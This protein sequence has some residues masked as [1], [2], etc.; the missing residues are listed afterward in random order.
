MKYS[1]AFFF[2]FFSFFF[3]LL[4]SATAPVAAEGGQW[5]LLQSSIGVSAMHMQLL[6]NDRV[7]IFDRTDFGPS[8]LSLGGGRCRDD[9]RDWNLKVDC[10]AHAAE[11][12]VA[13]NSVR[14]LMLLTDP[15]CSSGTLAP[16]GRLI[17]TGGANDGERGVRYLAACGEYD[18]DWEEDPSGLAAPRWYATNQVLPDGR[19]IVIGGRGQYNYEFIPKLNSEDAGTV[20][21]PLL[22]ETR[23]AEYNNLYPFVFLNLDGNLFIFANNKSILLDYKTNTVVRTYPA[24]PDG[25]PRNYPSTASAVLLPLQPSGTDAE[26]LICGGAPA[27]TYTKALKKV[28][29]GSL[30][31]CLRIS[32]ND[33]SPSW[34]VET[35]PT[36]RVMGDMLLLPSGEEVLIING[37]TAGSAGWDLGRDPVLSPVGY[38][39]GG[40]AGSRFDVKSPT[41]IPRMYHSS[42]V[43]LRDGR[44]LVGGSNPHAFYNF[45]GVDFPTDLS[46]EAYSPEYLAPENSNLRPE[47][48]SVA[49]APVALSYGKPF[50]LKFTVAAMSEKGIT[51]TMLA[52]SFAT[53]SL[54]MNQRLLILQSEAA[55]AVL[56]D[57]GASL[58]EVNAVAPMSAFMAPPGYYIVFVVNGGVPS[59][60]MWVHIQH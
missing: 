9:P 26:V 50:S 42:A 30:T 57:E 15:W 18:C 60:G 38:R 25:H 27:G 7:I 11:Y 55:A 23:D 21:F 2:F 6:H 10:T 4:C 1:F 56:A 44:V 12:D 47:I 35:M 39:H 24:A 14:P 20:D 48:I 19:A 8:N 41:T 37:A 43:L 58:Y 51:V 33:P 28:F 46:L 13:A 16:D 31:T 5:Q 52:P 54:S 59:E 45:T 40:P 34:S 3:L 29:V 17:Q 22:R 36:P 53:H 49:G 32:I